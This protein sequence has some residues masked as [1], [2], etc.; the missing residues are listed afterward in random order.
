MRVRVGGAD[1]GAPILEDQDVRHAVLRLQG[2]G[3]VAPCR[4]DGG[5]LVV[6]EVGQGPGGVV[7]VADD[8]GRAEARRVR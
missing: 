2:G 8:L 1:H 3:A 4:D 6:G 5:H 7:V